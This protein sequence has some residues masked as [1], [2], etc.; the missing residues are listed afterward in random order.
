[1]SIASSDSQRSR[2]GRIESVGVGNVESMSGLWENSFSRMLETETHLQWVE[3]HLG[4]A[5]GQRLS[6]DLSLLRKKREMSVT[7]VIVSEEMCLYVL[8]IR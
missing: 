4:S 6:V 2:K 3:E 8:M 5:E 1:M 7:A